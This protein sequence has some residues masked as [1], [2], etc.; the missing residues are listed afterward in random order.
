MQEQAPPE[1]RGRVVSIYGLAF[2]GGMPVGS[3]V[4]GFLV[5]AFGAALVLGSFA[6]LLAAAALAVRL[7]GGRVPSL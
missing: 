2:R 4:A 7:R 3:L 6:G 1:L 5:S